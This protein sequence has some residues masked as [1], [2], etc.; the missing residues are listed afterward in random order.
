MNHVHSS[1]ITLKNNET[2]FDWQ[3]TLKGAL[4]VKKLWPIVIRTEQRPTPTPPPLPKF[5]PPA[6][7]TLQIAPGTTE[8]Q[9]LAAQQQLKA[10]HQ[11]AVQTAQAT[12]NQANI[13]RST[14]HLNKYVKLQ[15]DFDKHASVALGMIYLSINPALKP[16][17][18]N[19]KSPAE[20]Y[21]AIC[22]R[23]KT[24]KTSQLIRYHSELFA[25]KME[26]NTNLHTHFNKI[27][28]LVRQITLVD[29]TPLE[30]MIATITISSLPSRFDAIKPIVQM[31]DA[32]NND[33]LRTVLLQH[34]LSSCEPPALKESLLLSRVHDSQRPS[35][36][37]DCGEND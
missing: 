35:K 1:P 9:V 28:T 33:K 3:Y 21:K 29:T 7:G 16:L 36:S 34:D 15:Q 10:Q 11:Q 27:N 22:G 24:N 8:A 31:W 19:L 25:L 6:H 4:L 2:F 30:A 20:A 37:K 17:V 32:V 26:G 5:I 14:D 18:A 13:K 12:A 23:Y